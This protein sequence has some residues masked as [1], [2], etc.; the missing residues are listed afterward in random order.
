MHVQEEVEKDVE[1][2]CE[3]NGGERRSSPP[4]YAH[5]R[6]CREEEEREGENNISPSRMHAYVHEEMREKDRENKMRRKGRRGHEISPTFPLHMHVL[7]GRVM[8][9]M[10]S[11]SQ[12]HF[13]VSFYVQ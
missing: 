13:H 12:S 11:I 8:D 10:W 2:R 1:E 4:P 9:I 3:E 7:V 6:E 5:K